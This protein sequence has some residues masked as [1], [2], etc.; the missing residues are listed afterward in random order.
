MSARNNPAIDP[1]GR[2]IKRIHNPYRQCTKHRTSEPAS[3]CLPDSGGW[4][5]PGLASCE[6]AIVAGA[7][8]LWCAIAAQTFNTRPG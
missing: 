8:R 6:M 4:T 7:L 2:R 1:N 5:A 3:D